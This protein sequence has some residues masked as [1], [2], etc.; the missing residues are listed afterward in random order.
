MSLKTS[1]MGILSLASLAATGLNATNMDITN[2]YLR[3]YLDMGQNKGAFRAGTTSPTITLKNNTNLTFTN[4]TIPDFRASILTSGVYTNNNGVHTSSGDFTALGGAYTASVKHILNRTKQTYGPT[5]Y[6]QTNQISVPTT[7][8]NKSVAPDSRYTRLDKYVVETVGVKPINMDTDKN[9]TETVQEIQKLLN[10]SRFQTTYNGKNMTIVYRAGAGTF[11]AYQNLK[12]YE[13]VNSSKKV[14]SSGAY[15]SSNINGQ[16]SSLNISMINTTVNGTEIYYDAFTDKNNG[17]WQGW[18]NF[19]SAGDSG[20]GVYIYDNEAK[21]WRYL[22]SH[23]YS[24]NNTAKGSAVFASGLEF[25][26]YVA[27]HT[28]NYSRNSDR[29]CIYN[30]CFLTQDKL[31]KVDGNYHKD[32]N[33]TG[34]GILT[35]NSNL[36]QNGGGLI[37]ADGK[38][39]TLAGSGSYKGAGLDIAKNGVVNLNVTGVY[40]DTLHKIGEGTLKVNVAQKTSYKTGN[41]LTELN[42]KNA[43]ERIYLTNSLATIKFG[44]AGFDLNKISF[45]YGGGTLDLNGHNAY[46]N[47]INS[48]DFGTKITNKNAKAS[49]LT[50]ANTDNFLLHGNINGNINLVAISGAGRLVFDGGFEV[51]NATFEN[52]NIILQGHAVEHAVATEDILKQVRKVEANTSRSYYNS[53]NPSEFEQPDWD[54]RVYNANTLNLKNATLNIMRNSNLTANITASNSYVYIGGSKLGSDGVVA[55][56]RLDSLNSA[57]GTE[58]WTVKQK[59]EFG[60]SQNDTSINV[61][62]NI[63]ATKTNIVN[64]ANAKF[65]NINLNGS[66]YF[67]D[68]SDHITFANLTAANKSYVSS[69]LFKLTNA[70]ITTDNTTH[71]NVRQIQVTNGTLNLDVKAPASTLL[72]A[73]NSNVTVKQWHSA[74]IVGDNASHFNFD[75]LTLNGNNNTIN[76]NVNITKHLNLL[77]VGNNKTDQNATDKFHALRV[78]GT[79]TLANDSRVSVSFNKD[80]LLA[81]NFAFNKNYTLVNATNLQDNRSDKTL[82]YYAVGLANNTTLALNSSSTNT[83]LSF[84]FVAGDKNNATLKNSTVS[85]QNY[86]SSR[87]PEIDINAV[88]ANVDPRYAE[89]LENLYQHNQNSENAL[90]EVML[91]ISQNN[92]EYANALGEKSEMSLASIGKLAAQSVTD[93][94]LGQSIRLTS[95]QPMLSYGLLT[96]AVAS[97]VPLVNL[98]AIANAQ[99]TKD[100]VFGGISGGFYHENNGDTSKVYGAHLGAKKEFGFGLVGVSA[101]FMQ[102]SLEGDVVDEEAKVFDVGIFARVGGE[103]LELVSNLNA[104]YA[105]SVRNGDYNF[106][107]QREPEWRQNSWQAQWSN[108]LLV[109]VG[110]KG[111]SVEVRP[112][113]QADVGYEKLDAVSVGDFMETKGLSGYY[114]KA[115]VG[116]S[117]KF[118]G[119]ELVVGAKRV[120]ARENEEFLVRFKGAENYKAYKRERGFEFEVSVSGGVNVGQTSKIFYRLELDANDK[121]GFGGNGEVGVEVKF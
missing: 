61:N 77:N 29:Y 19:N 63:T 2:V 109:G 59:L 72:N 114:A 105:K 79:L 21:E 58:G 17:N 118:D 84:Q 6:T 92:T 4:L 15:N 5:T 1:Y 102:S 69:N 95:V 53:G 13:R 27:A 54:T 52:K 76:A 83:T 94:A 18:Y 81:N 12:C 113:L 16:I 39:Y 64:Y 43:F 40:G 68:F 50:I 14:V 86:N 71:F 78:N 46:A 33:I 44:E 70:S 97:D 30:V 93:R 55:L 73:T 42:V 3:D 48:Y 37:F 119:T 112:Y 111:E 56:D 74:N 80:V 67:L 47:Y 7:S 100:V 99:E 108:R 9:G 60:S 82:S 87:T 88:K 96:A 117:A 120:V 31:E 49:Q 57:Y 85:L 75:S 91:Y 116:V 38:T 24:Y 26:K 121:G 104:A 35:I 66:N 11:S 98:V 89:A 28:Q 25:E 51:K 8:G 103:S 22:G 65:G 90:Q 101:G 32:L 115:G 45:G 36:V 20:S 110:L 106:F 34:G 62:A 10:S 41:G 107:G 23:A